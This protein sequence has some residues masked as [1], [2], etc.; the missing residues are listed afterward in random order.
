MPMYSSPVPSDPGDE[1]PTTNRV[2]TECRKCGK[3]FEPTSAQIKKYFI[4]SVSPV[5]P[6]CVGPKPTNPQNVKDTM[7]VRCE[8]CGKVFNPTTAEITNN[9]YCGLRYVCPDCK[10][11]PPAAQANP[12]LDY[13]E[14]LISTSNLANIREIV[15]QQQELVKELLLAFHQQ[16][17]Q[18]A[19]LLAD[20]A[21]LQNRIARLE[22]N[23][24]RTWTV[25]NV[26][27]RFIGD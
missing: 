24:P 15:L 13:A 16:E 8:E 23:T 6:D 12:A 21:L 18:I 2:T 14:S 3:V 25:A 26:D 7:A 20:N 5:C 9:V 1:Q 22:A 17:S 10:R 11:R 27:P 4:G 19:T